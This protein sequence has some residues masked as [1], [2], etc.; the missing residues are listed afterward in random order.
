MKSKPKRKLSENEL[1]I[2]VFSGEFSMCFISI[3]LGI[4][5]LYALMSVGGFLLSFWYYKDHQ[6]ENFTKRN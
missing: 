3:V 2:L 1:M 6:N 5:P 4:L